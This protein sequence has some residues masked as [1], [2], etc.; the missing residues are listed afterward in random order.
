M[1]MGSRI[2]ARGGIRSVAVDERRPSGRPTL[3]VNYWYA[4]PVGHAIEGLRYALGYRAANPE[5]E[6]SLLLNA[7]TPVELATCCPSLA[8]TFAVPFVHF[9]RLVGDPAAALAD[10][11]RRWDYVVDNHRAYLPSHD[12][13]AGFRGFYDAAHLHF[14][15]GHGFGLCGAAPPAYAPHQQLRLDLPD[16][17][18]NAA[19]RIL[20]GRDT[21][22]VVLAG[23]SDAR[24][25]Y[26]SVSSW[27]LILGGLS[28]RH[29]GVALA[30]IGKLGP[31][32]ARSTTRIDRAE[33]DRLL[34]ALPTAID[35][36]DRPLM[37]Q[38][39]V[40]EASRLFLSPH[41]GFGF[42]A[43]SVGTPWLTISGGQWHEGFMNG[44]AFYSVLPD[45]K[46]YPCFAWGGPLP[47]I[48]LD[49]DGEG[50][51]T[52]SMCAAR[53]R[54]DLRELLDAADLLMAGGLTYEQSLA[55]Y[56][57]RLFA[58]YGGDPSRLFSFDNIHERYLP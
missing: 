2:T 8:R 51:R 1:R 15:P 50:P 29:P 16:E 21:I 32:T 58:A 6:V 42:A 39:A 13:Y 45:V 37:E 28:R 56:F 12:A 36:F 18:R 53:I 3:L 17:A 26:P 49:E 34:Q 30:L 7:G 22:S 47:L 40:V 44:V 33:V 43:V 4:H 35:C 52:P 9:G 20:R 48:E 31:G 46:R 5:M 57:P 41:T 25:F 14:E 19:R 24:A 38:L 55:N 10:V 27:T 11:P 23:H 54:A